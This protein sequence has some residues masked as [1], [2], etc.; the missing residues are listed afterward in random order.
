MFEVLLTIRLIGRLLVSLQ[1]D[2]VVD[3]SAAELRCSGETAKVLNLLA[4]LMNQAPIKAAFVNLASG[5]SK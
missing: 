1:E 2:E 3:S 4:F 5:K